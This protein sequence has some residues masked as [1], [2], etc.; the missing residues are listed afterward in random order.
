MKRQEYINWDEFGMGL[1]LIAAQRSK[2]PNTQ[3]GACI[4]DE[5]HMVLGVGYNGFPYG[6]SDNKFRWDKG[7]GLNKYFFSV[8]AEANA[9]LSSDYNRIKN[10]IIY[11]TLFPCNECA[12]LII[13]SGIKEVVYLSNKDSDKNFHKASIMML[14][15]AG[16]KYRQFIS[17]RREIVLK[18]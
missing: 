4:L 13:Q 18:L 16:I 6:C 11:T 12:K 3:V 2:D 5:K 10:S 1:A 7:D 9:I 8:H 15:S 17:K 14:D